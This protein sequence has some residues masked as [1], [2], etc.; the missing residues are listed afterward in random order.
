[1]RAW[2]T[3]LALLVTAGLAAMSMAC[4]A[5]DSS[6]V[7][8]IKN[9]NY[10]EVRQ[11]SPVTDPSVVTVTE[12]FWYG[13]PHCY[14]FDPTLNDWAK[15][16]PAD[17]KFSRLPSSLGR[18]IGIIHARMFWTAKELGIE[19]KVHSAIFASIHREHQ[20]MA[21]ADQISALF[22]SVTGIMPDIVTNTYNGDKVKEDVHNSEVQ[23]RDWGVTSVPTLVVGGR[24]MTSP[25]M[26]DGFESTLATT[27]ALIAKV[28]AEQEAEA[29]K[30]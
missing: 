11:V 8:L 4:S 21:T 20:A 7:E 26:N 3:G 29:A 16:L 12:V 17:V 28:R 23:V 13:C 15:K 2:K 22:N 10:E 9:K 5:A 19:D 6:S 24:Y 1:M 14:A 27:D 25:V 18:P 30:K